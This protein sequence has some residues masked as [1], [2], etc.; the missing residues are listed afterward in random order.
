MTHLDSIFISHE[1]QRHATANWR[2]KLPAVPPLIYTYRWQMLDLILI[3]Y[4]TALFFVTDR[5]GKGKA[6]VHKKVV[7][8][9]DNAGSYKSNQSPFLLTTS[10]QLLR[11]DYLNNILY[12]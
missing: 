11:S 10:M 3:S 9:Q 4:G 7:S 1:H 2:Q 5:D 8:P 6:E 12:I